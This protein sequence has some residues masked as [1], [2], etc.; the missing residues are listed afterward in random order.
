M[1]RRRKAD[2][3]VE[4]VELM[5]GNGADSEAAA[6]AVRKIPRD[7]GELLLKDQEDDDDPK[8]LTEPEYPTSGAELLVEELPRDYS[9][10]PINEQAAFR[11][12]DRIEQALHRQDNSLYDMAMGFLDAYENNYHVVWG[13]SSFQVYVE[14]QLNL[15]MRFAYYMVDIA[16]AL[17]QH[18]IPVDVVQRIG[19]TKLSR[20]CAAIQENPAEATRYLEMA[21]GMSRA[22][23][24]EALKDEILAIPGKPETQ[25]KL[26]V[27]CVFEGHAAEVVSEA[28]GIA[29]GDIGQKNMSIAFQHIAGEW[30]A[31]RGAEQSGLA[32]EDWVNHLERVFGTKLVRAESEDSIDSL[33]TGP[34]ATDEDERML[35]DLLN[36]TPEE[37]E[38]L[39][40]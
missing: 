40:S 39:T 3:D 13:Y 1:A 18:S 33:I 23:L 30:L 8:L 4:D 38:E 10:L 17:R 27:A 11:C 21:E 36:S 29:Y 15:K 37:L 32:L 34:A 28:I 26:R 12:K 6:P 20:V 7:F 14:E 24:E 25:D 2:L 22:R 35:E 9:N 31:A 16:K 19:W 5:G